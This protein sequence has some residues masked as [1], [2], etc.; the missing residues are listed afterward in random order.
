MDPNRAMKRCVDDVVW[1]HQQPKTPV[2][3]NFQVKK[4]SSADG[5]PVQTK[6]PMWDNGWG[7]GHPVERGS[8]PELTKLPGVIYFWH[9]WFTLLYDK[10]QTPW[11]N[12]YQNIHLYICTCIM[13]LIT[14]NIYTIASTFKWMNVAKHH[15]RCCFSSTKQREVHKRAQPGHGLSWLVHF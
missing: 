11:I 5:V 13:C 4:T 10:Q 1:L 6:Q 14:H 12:S 2:T 7:T 8:I 3:S 15:G 9:I